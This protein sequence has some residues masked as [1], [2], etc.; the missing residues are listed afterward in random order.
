M[1]PLAVTSVQDLEPA[2]HPCR[3]R[4]AV[5]A[6]VDA[7][8]AIEKASF[9]APW[10]KDAIDDEIDSRSFTYTIVAATDTSIVGFMVYWTV[11]GEMH[12]INLAVAPSH[13][14]HG[15]GRALMD[16]LIDHAQKT[17]C[18]EILLEVRPSN[19]P[20]RALYDALGFEAIGIRIG[21]YADND[22]DA[23]VLSLRVDGSNAEET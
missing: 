22:E 10:T 5:K 14:G 7:I 2:E 16:H 12:L 13:R 18:S 4:R 23:L 21:Y 1:T 6:D 3:I 19:A 11:A 9:T 8:Y 20:A 17:R 15:I